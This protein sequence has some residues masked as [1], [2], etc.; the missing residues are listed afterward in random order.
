[1]I[2]SLLLFVIFL[3]CVP[4]AI[5]DQVETVLPSPTINQNAESVAEVKLH[6]F[7]L[8]H[9]ASK[10]NFEAWSGNVWGTVG[11]LVIVIGWLFT[12]KSARIFLS[13]Q[14]GARYVALAAVG[15]IAAINIGLNIILAKRSFVLQ[16]LLAKS[17]Y[18]IQHKLQTEHFG[19]YEVPLF[20]AILSCVLVGSMFVLILYLLLAMR[21]WKEPVK[22]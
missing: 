15:V 11:S 20:N 7:E 3:C 5:A 13:R 17:D 16:E 2:N 18:V 9:Q 1:M 8:L 19:T 12:A 14:S 4:P 22:D 21:D 6:K 10:E